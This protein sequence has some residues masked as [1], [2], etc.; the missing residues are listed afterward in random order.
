MC[1]EK[2][3]ADLYTKFYNKYTQKC[4]SSFQK[5]TIFMKCV[6]MHQ[7][8]LVLRK[9]HTKANGINLKS[10]SVL[11]LLTS[12]TVHYSLFVAAG[13]SVALIPDHQTVMT[14]SINA[15]S[16]YIQSQNNYEHSSY[17]YHC[18]VTVSLHSL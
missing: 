12:T 1:Y 4:N 2:P 3:S 17:R 16:S 5:Y 7:I 11:D 15:M 6:H 9:E 8:V 13:H 10:S 18:D 14:S